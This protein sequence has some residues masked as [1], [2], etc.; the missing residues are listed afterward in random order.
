M[1][2]YYVHPFAALLVLTTAS[3]GSQL[4]E[5][6]KASAPMPSSSL[7]QIA[8]PRTGGGQWSPELIPEH[9]MVDSGRRTCYGHKSK[10]WASSKMRFCEPGCQIVFEHRIIYKVV[11]QS[12]I[13]PVYQTLGAAMVSK[14]PEKPIQ[15]EGERK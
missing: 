10:C 12:F 11:P 2:K 9:I 15:P 5:P 1:R 4:P 13:P 6:E 3:Q 14:A 7:S 8:E